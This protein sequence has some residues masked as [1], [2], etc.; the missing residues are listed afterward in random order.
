MV[1]RSDPRWEEGGLPTKTSTHDD[2]GFLDRHDTFWMDK[3]WVALRRGR[4]DDA[5]LVAV[6]QS[7]CATQVNHILG[8]LVC[9]SCG[10]RAVSGTVDFG[11]WVFS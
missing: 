9:E 3:L 6:G 7:E 10:F 1:R 4:P 2:S 8:E 11:G 5:K